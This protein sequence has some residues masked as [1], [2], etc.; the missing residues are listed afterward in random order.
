MFYLFRKIQVISKRC[1][2]IKFVS[3]GSFSFLLAENMTWLFLCIPT[4]FSSHIFHSWNLTYSFET[5]V[6]DISFCLVSINGMFN[7]YIWNFCRVFLVFLS[8]LTTIFK[9]VNKLSK[10]LKS[11][12]SGVESKSLKETANIFKQIYLV[13][14]K[15]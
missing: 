11:D 2:N 12:K 4:V 9:D 1:F 5:N 15:S 3:N 6:F 14:K 13:F 10:N 8:Y 7:M